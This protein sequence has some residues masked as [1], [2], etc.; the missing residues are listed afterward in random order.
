MVARQAF[1]DLA[2]D[3]FEEVEDGFALPARG[4]AAAAERLIDG[5]DAANFEQAGFGVVRVVGEQLELR[6]DHF[7]VAGGARGLDLAVDGDGLAGVEF[8]VQD[9]CR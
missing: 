7:E 6:L 5:R 4:Q 8:A 1:G 3:R 2:A 9:K